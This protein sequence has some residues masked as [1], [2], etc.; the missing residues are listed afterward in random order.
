V[1]AGTAIR[2]AESEII[3]DSIRVVDSAVAFLEIKSPLSPL[4]CYRR[5]QSTVEKNIRRSRFCKEPNE[6]LKKMISGRV[7]QS[8]QG[9]DGHAPFFCAAK[10]NSK[11]TLVLDIFSQSS[12]SLVATMPESPI[13]S[14]ARIA[15]LQ[16][17][18][19]PQ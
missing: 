19:N 16:G 10:S 14:F 11:E 4:L 17:Q 6:A 18:E 1:A 9:R 3:S 5:A 12:S 7:D 13:T 8:P 2:A 15:G